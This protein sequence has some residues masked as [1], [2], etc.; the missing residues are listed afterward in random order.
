M[1]D[2]TDDRINDAA[3]CSVCG[4]PIISIVI[5]GPT[6]AERYAQPC[7]H[8]LPPGFEIEGEGDGDSGD[9]EPVEGEEREETGTETDT[10][11][12]TD[13]TIETFTALLDRLREIE[14]VHDGVVHDGHSSAWIELVIDGPLIGPAVLREI[15]DHHCG[16]SDVVGSDVYIMASAQEVTV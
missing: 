11:A 4:T 12:R 8:R 16:I 1:T 2:A 3:E 5:R 9:G 7:G 10:D 14:A 6:P 15:A 13:T